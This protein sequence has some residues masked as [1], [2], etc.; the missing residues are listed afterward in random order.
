MNQKPGFTLK[1]TSAGLRKARNWYELAPR[2]GTRS[3]PTRKAGSNTPGGWNITSPTFSNCILTCIASAT[4][5]FHLEDLL[6]TLARSWFACSA[7]LRTLDKQREGDPRWF[8]SNKMLGGVIHVD[9]FAGNLEGARGKIPYVKVI[10]TGNPHVLGAMR[11]H[12]G[13]RAYIFA[14][15]SEHEQHIQVGDPVQ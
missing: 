8:Q 14:N 10:E 11:I 13:K 2:F 3:P 12:A 15:F 9:L 7:S 6:V 4:I 5:F 1:S